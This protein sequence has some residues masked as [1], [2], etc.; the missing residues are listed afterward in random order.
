MDTYLR[1]KKHLCVL[2]CVALLLPL[3]GCMS[4]P[5]TALRTGTNVSIGSEPLYLA[6]ELG[7]LARI[8]VAT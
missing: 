2:A 7:R 5:E 4:E 3:I 1:A 8:V 6:R